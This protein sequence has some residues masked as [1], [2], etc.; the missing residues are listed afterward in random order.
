MIMTAEQKRAKQQTEDFIIYLYKKYYPRIEEEM[1]KREGQKKAALPA[2]FVIWGFSYFPTY[3]IIIKTK[4]GGRKMKQKDKVYIYTRVS[5]AMQTEGY[6]LEAQKQRILDYVKYRDFI[7]AGEYSDAGFSG[8]NIAGRVQF[9]QMLSDIESKK[10]DIKYVLVFKLSRFGRNCADTLASLQFMQDYGVNLICVEDN[11]DSSAGAGKLMISV[12]S[13]M[14]EIERE[15]ILEQT[16]S[17]RKQKARSGGWNGGFAPY[18]YKLENGLLI[19][20]ADEAEAIKE[21]YDLYVNTA[22]GPTAIASAINKKYKKI[23]RSNGYLTKFTMSIVKDILD[24]PVYCG[25]IA[26]G[27]HSTEKIMGKRNEYHIVKQTDQDKIIIAE[28][29]HEAIVSEELW[30]AAH[31]KR[32]A[33]AKTKEKIDKEHEYCLSGILRCPSCGGPMYGIHNGRKTKK[34]GTPYAM[35][36]SYAC[37]SSSQTGVDC[38]T[39]KNYSENKLMEAVTSIIKALVSDKNFAK[40]VD[41]ALD[42]QTDISG[43]EA[44]KAKFQKEVARLK[45]MVTQLENQLM[46]L[47]YGNKSDK[48]RETSLNRRLDA[49][50]E[51]IASIQDQI[52]E[53]DEKIEKVVEAERTKKGVYS[54]LQSFDVLFDVMDDRD[55]KLLL[56]EMIDSIELYPRKNRSGQWIKTIHFKFPMYYN[57]SNEASTDICFDM[58]GNFLPKR[59]NDE[60]I[61]TLIRE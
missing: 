3:D 49:A 17:G 1:E 20:Q 29:K 38:K 22:Y 10:D 14:A 31:K 61:V 6:S 51:E 2:F 36:Y 54:V 15:N 48:L 27:R 46:T 11:I 24:N 55:K 52:A 19:V 30:E 16:M 33:N 47:D 37:R 39:P 5:T 59:S 4:S 32:L 40:M 18:G 21:I 44:E 50:L 53:V 41:V 23:P 8:K 45:R 57:D 12:M 35:S 42:Q 26:Y 43:L 58:E 56:N 13:A 25:K 60:S 7:V 28:G 9:Q 34:D